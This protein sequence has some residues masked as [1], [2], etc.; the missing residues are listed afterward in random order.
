MT[1]NLYPIGTVI[2]GGINT[3]RRFHDWKPGRRHVVVGH[4]GDQ[5]VCVTFTCGCCEYGDIK[6]TKTN[7]L[8]DLADVV[9]DVKVYVNDLTKTT[10][11][12]QLTKTEL[13]LV[14]NAWKGD[15]RKTTNV[16]IG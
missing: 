8:T 15:T 5:L 3:T 1:N 6:P 4:R 9:T 14:V 10:R 16:T 11:V 7:G 13:E 12:G 2:K